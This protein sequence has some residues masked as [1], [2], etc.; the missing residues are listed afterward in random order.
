[1]HNRLQRLRIFLIAALL[2]ACGSVTDV[3]KPPDTNTPITPTDTIA[4]AITREM[5]GLWVATVGNIDWPSKQ[6]LT[7]DQQKAELVDILDR[8][9][10][11]GLNTIVF[12]VRPA[13]D[14][15]YN[16]ALEPWG[17]MFSG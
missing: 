10:A 1:M 4:P 2:A 9:V 13:A 11:A 8:A 6:G 3:N 7:A 17:F 5:R 14:A 12:H 16:S 15:L